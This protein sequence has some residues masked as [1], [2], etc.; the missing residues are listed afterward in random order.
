MNEINDEFLDLSKQFEKLSKNCMRLL[1]KEC[2][3]FFCFCLFDSLIKLIIVFF[4]IRG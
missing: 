3:K 2:R 4:L 1:F